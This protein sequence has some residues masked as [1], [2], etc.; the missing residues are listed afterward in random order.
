MKNSTAAAAAA[1]A[2]FPGDRLTRSSAPGWTGSGGSGGGLEAHDGLGVSSATGASAVT[3]GGAGESAPWLMVG[4]VSVDGPS[5]GAASAGGSRSGAAACGVSAGTSTSSVSGVA[6]SVG[7]SSA[8]VV[9]NVP[10]GGSSGPVVANVPAVESSALDVGGENGVTG[11]SVR[12]AA[13]AASA[14]DSSALPGEG[15]TAPNGAV[16]YSVPRSED[17][18][19]SSGICA[20]SIS[21][22]EGGSAGGGASLVGSAS[23]RHGGVS[24]GAEESDAVGVGSDVRSAGGGDEYAAGSLSV[25]RL[26]RGRV[27][28][29]PRR[30]VVAIAPAGR[31]FAAPIDLGVVE[32][33]VGV[34][35]AFLGLVDA[36]FGADAGRAADLLR[37]V[38]DTDRLGLDPG[39]GQGHETRLGVAD[40]DQDPFGPAG[41]TVEVDLTNTAEPLPARIKDVAAGP[42]AV[43][44]ELGL[45]GQL[46]HTEPFPA[47]GTAHASGSPTGAVDVSAQSEDDRI[48]TSVVAPGRAPRQSAQRSARRLCRCSRKRS[49][50]RP[51]RS[52]R[53]AR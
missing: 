32:A 46:S 9:A 7:G 43:V 34:E 12:N 38:G 16:S 27:A 6:E 28:G 51:S 30:A 47:N 3:G 11:S 5:I 21:A 2:I 4:G 10:A 19:G 14:G 36:R 45:G 15:A 33:V 42:I 40:V 31:G 52:P 41:L 44:A 24:G 13:A 26:G 22:G 35:A 23:V 20:D 25:A 50:T 49:C 53:T 8:S 18:G 29:L 39:V 17:A 37:V 1:P 48:L